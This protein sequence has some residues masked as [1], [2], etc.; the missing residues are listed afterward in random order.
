VDRLTP[1]LQG[2]ILL[3][4]K[5][6]AYISRKLKNIVGRASIILGEHAR[7]G[8]FEPIGLELDFG[9]GKTLPPLI[10]PLPNG[11]VMEVIGRIDR[12]DMAQGAQGM[13]LRVIDY[14]SS[15]ND[16]KLHEVY[17][18]LSLQLLT[19]LDVLLTYSEEWLGAAAM[20][21]GTLYFH[22]HDPLLQSA[23]GMNAEQAADELLKRFKMKGLL[24]SNRDVI[25]Q[26][27]TSLDK[28]HSAILPVAV[29]SDGSFYSSAAVATSEQWDS[30]LSSVRSNI[31]NIGT[32]ITEGDVKIEPYR[33]QHETACT[34]CSYKPVCH[35]D[36]NVE[37]NHYHI[38][39][40]PNKSQVW[41]MLSK[42]QGGDTP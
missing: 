21:A 37:G 26:M 7:R 42:T 23:N 13:M 20:P 4:S 33:I 1:L 41:D 17:Y 32:R 39:G 25:A 19:Y 14:K 12:V 38:M 28:G 15:Q 27:D 9:P 30:L 24:L 10:F 29:K 35:F 31:V 6:Y 34:F 5:R 8:N 40:K 36:E 16:L 18:G 2:E 3:S 22:V 11:S